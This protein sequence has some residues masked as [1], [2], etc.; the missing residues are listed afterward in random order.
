[1]EDPIEAPAPAEPTVNPADYPELGDRYRSLT[2]DTL[3]I[4]GL[5]FA[6]AYLFAVWP[7]A[8]EGARKWAFGLIWFG[9]EP[10]ATSLGCTFGNYVMRIRVR[11]VGDESRRINLLQAYVRYPVKLLLGW[12]SFITMGGNAKRRAIHDMAS[13]SVVVKVGPHG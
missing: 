9:Y 4:I 12:L 7:N 6:A 11:R 3:V 2:I 1:M 8:P 10:V 5:M 13:G